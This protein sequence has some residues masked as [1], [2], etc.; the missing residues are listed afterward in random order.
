M[1]LLT[2]NSSGHLSGSFTIPPNIVAGK[3]LVTF[4]GNEQ[5]SASAI[6][7]GSNILITETENTTIFKERVTQPRVD[8]VAQ[9]FMLPSQIMLSG[10]DL[11]FAALG[12][13]NI[14][15]Q[16]RNTNDGVPGETI[17]AEAELPASSCNTTTYT[18]FPFEFPIIIEANQEYAIVI[19][20]NDAVSAVKI[21]TLGQYDTEHGHWITSQ[22]YAIGVLLSS[23]NAVTWTPHQ[24]SDLAFRLLSPVFS[25]TSKTVNLGNVSVI[26]ATDLMVLADIYL[27]SPDCFVNFTLTFSDQSTINCAANQPIELSAAYTGQ[28]DIVA[29]M[30]GTSSRAP[31][32]GDGVSVISGVL[33]TEGLYISRAFDCNGANAA[34]VI[35]DALLAGS[36]TFNIYF[37]NSSAAYVEMTGGTTKLL[38][39]GYTEH[40]FAPTGIAL[41]ASTRIKIKMDGTATGRPKLKKLRVAMT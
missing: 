11:W 12:T 23:S 32:L 20:C 3:K 7:T 19:Q 4:T 25:E 24:I 1:S 16:I 8:P 34:T 5:S 14:I 22:P 10:V 27:P 15:V 2:A 33:D 13:S 38:D 26:G 35:I 21:A 9:T 39:N 30:T 17:F 28:I 6:Y 36:S 41:G 37:L 18:R 29:N 40:A 31:V